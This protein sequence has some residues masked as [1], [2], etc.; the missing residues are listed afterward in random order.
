MKALKILMII[1]SIGLIMVGLLGLIIPEQMMKLFGFDELPDST[2]TT[3]F[4][5]AGIY[6]AAGFWAIISTKNLVSNLVWIK[7][8]LTKA[9][10]SIVIFIYL[11]IQS[12][13]SLGTPG[14]ISTM[15]IDAAFI[16]LALVLYPWQV[17][18]KATLEKNQ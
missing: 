2:R 12:Y 16:M 9:S 5:L 17:K 7:L 13:T 1:Y 3:L 15:V 8:L 6:I 14:A 11:A 18:Q 10:F 4:L